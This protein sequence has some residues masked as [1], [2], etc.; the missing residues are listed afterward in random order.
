MGGMGLCRKF[1]SRARRPRPISRTCEVRHVRYDNLKPAVKQVCFGRSRIESQRWVAFRSHYQ[2]DA[3]F[4]MPGKDGAHE[5]GRVE[6]EGGRF[7]RSHLVPVPE[8][9][10]LAELNERL[11]AMDAAEDARH[12]Q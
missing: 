6:H 7:R 9:T 1:M 10:S 11:A 5:K 2:F 12:V 8:V 4:C 3:F